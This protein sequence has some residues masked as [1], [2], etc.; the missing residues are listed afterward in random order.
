MPLADELAPEAAKLGIRGAVAIDGGFAFFHRFL[1]RT[2][3]EADITDPTGVL[4]AD[5][6]TILASHS[7]TRTPIVIGF[8]YGT[9]MAAALLLARPDLLA[10]VRPNG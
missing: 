3:D 9:T 1:D 8:S 5:I 7:V 6:E 4:A 10:G 2:I